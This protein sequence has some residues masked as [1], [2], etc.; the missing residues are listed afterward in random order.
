MKAEEYIKNNP[1]V[2]ETNEDKYFEAITKIAIDL[3]LE[4]K[5]I[6][7]ARHVKTEAGA[8]SIFR[9]LNQKA[10]KIARIIKTESEAR[11]RVDGLTRFFPHSNWWEVCMEKVL[12]PAI[13]TNGFRW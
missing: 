1:D 9:E 5:T 6:L 13:H 3:F 2:L 7:D 12:F 10:K 4:S 8:E 11:T